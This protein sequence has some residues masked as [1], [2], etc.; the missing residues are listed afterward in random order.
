MNGRKQVQPSAVTNSGFA[1]SR[2]P[3]FA[4]DPCLAGHSTNPDSS[5]RH[6]AASAYSCAADPR[7][8]RFAPNSGT[9]GHSADPNST[10][11]DTPIASDSGFADPRHSG[12]AAHSGTTVASRT[13]A[14]PARLGGTR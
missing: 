1:D 11:R 3:R 2:H 5:D 6:S 9:P 13:A 7:I 8:A 12:V 14:L 10:R 4:A